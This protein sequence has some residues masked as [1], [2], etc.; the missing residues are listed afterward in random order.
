MEAVEW[1]LNN[2][3]PLKVVTLDQLTDALLKL[4]P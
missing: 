1:A 4:V 2:E 3:H